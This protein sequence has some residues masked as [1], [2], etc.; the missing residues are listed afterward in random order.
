MKNGDKIRALS[1]EDLA[2]ILYSVCVGSFC[3]D[4]PLAQ[5]CDGIFRVTGDW[6][7][8]LEIEAEE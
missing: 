8:W 1:N 3:D 4:C 6:Y 5:L 7:D 2:D